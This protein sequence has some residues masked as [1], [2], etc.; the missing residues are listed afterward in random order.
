MYRDQLAAVALAVVL[1]LVWV[2]VT[3][4]LLSH[5]ERMLHL[6]PLGV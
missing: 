4:W 3:G 1:L 6:R 5:G 2:G